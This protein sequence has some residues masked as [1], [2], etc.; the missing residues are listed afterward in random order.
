[1]TIS[2]LYEQLHGRSGSTKQHIYD[3]FSADAIDNENWTVRDL[4]GSGVYTQLDVINE[5]FE[6]T[7]S[8]GGASAIDSNGKRFLNFD[9]STVI[10]VERCLGITS[11]NCVSGANSSIAYGNNFY[12]AGINTPGDTTNFVLRTSDT[13]APSNTSLAEPLDIVFH[14]FKME[15]NASDCLCYFDGPL[16]A[17]K[18]TDMP[19]LKLQPFMFIQDEAS[20]AKSIRIRYYEAFNR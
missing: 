19:T 6:I 2:S 11:V 3:N 1:M 18:T 7:T 16:K 15:Q 4:I 9:S 10:C 20:A 14:T 5:G 13:T 8:S 12:S 17:T